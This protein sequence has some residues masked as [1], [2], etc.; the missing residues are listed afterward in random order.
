MLEIGKINHLK[1][2][3]ATAHGA[4]L[5]D[6]QG[7]EVL[8]PKK[9][10]ADDL[11]LEDELDV[12]VFTDSEDRITATTQTPFA[13]RDEFAYLQV[14][15]VT[16]HGT[17]LDWGLDKDLL[18][19]FREQAKR[20]NK[21]QYYIVYVYLDEQSDRL[22]ASSKVR[23]FLETRYIDLENSEKVKILVWEQTDLGL[24]VIINDSYLGLI[25]NEDLHTTLK[26][27][28]RLNA[29]IKNIRP[30]K[31]IDVVLHK[32]GF[33]A[34]E[35]N[36]QRILLKIRENKGFLPLH[37]KSDP[38]DIKE[39]LKMSKKAFKKAIGIL[40]KNKLIRITNNGLHVIDTKKI[41]KRK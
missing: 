27:G 19:P 41:I 31:K 36:A 29:Y 39:Q 13:Q 9:F 1:V 12:F 3:R 6:N 20:M 24:N 8:L 38:R 40:Y 18:V 23:R 16:S 32:P 15:D 2:N 33:A 17:F 25:F 26:P 34:I 30:D 4:Y 21:G 14:R 28:D 7:S 22:A 11:R 35:P 10:V 5:V 37:D